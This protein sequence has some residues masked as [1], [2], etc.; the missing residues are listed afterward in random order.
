MNIL[1]AVNTKVKQQLINCIYSIVRFNNRYDIYILHSDFGAEDIGEVKDRFLKD[2]SI[3][4][5]YV[6]PELTRGFP[7]SRRYPKEIYYRLFA[8]QV[9]PGDLDRI[10]YLDA[11]TV[12]INPLDELYGAEFDGAYYI[13]CTHIRKALTKAN[14]KRLGVKGGGVY[15]NTGVML[16]NLKKLREE[17]SLTEIR[18]FAEKNA[19]RLLL[20][21]Q[22][23]IAALYGR[24]IKTSD[25]M[26]YNLTERALMLHNAGARREKRDIEWVR[27]NTVIIHYIG[28]SKPWENGCSGTLGVFYDELKASVNS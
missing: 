21:D 15:I 12:V 2:V 20:P 4:F 13:G 26:R 1:F 19:S 25:S 17:Q 16:I 23:I 22:D 10:L 5:I 9:L 11:D 28:K 27:R 7:V 8:A 18:E 6:S 24:N 14:Q 3:T